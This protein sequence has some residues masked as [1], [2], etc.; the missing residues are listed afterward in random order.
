MNTHCM[1]KLTLTYDTLKKRDVFVFTAYNVESMLVS[2]CGA[3]TSY[4][5]ALR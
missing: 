5:K 3:L 2:V 4:I 1:L